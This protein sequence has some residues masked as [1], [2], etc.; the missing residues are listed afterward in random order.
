VVKSTRLSGL[1]ALRGLAAVGVV[2]YH[3]TIGYE[4]MFGQHSAAL[5]PH[6]LIQLFH[7]GHFGVELFF[8]ISGFVILMTLERSESLVSFGIS[9]FARLYPPY[10]ACSALTLGVIVFA[11]FNPQHLRF[12]DALAGL[13]MAS[14][15]F[16]RPEIDPSDWTLTYEVIF[17][18]LVGAFYF[19]RKSR[20]I[21]MFCL[22]GMAISLPFA[23]NIYYAYLFAAGMM[24]YRFSSGK[25]VA[26]TWVTFGAVLATPILRTRATAAQHLLYVLMIFAFMALVWLAG[27]GKLRQLERPVL[28]FLGDISYSLYLLHQIIGYWLI[29]RLEKW[30]LRPEAAVMAALSVSIGLASASRFLVELPVQRRIRQIYTKTFDPGL[31]VEPPAAA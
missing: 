19:A 8:I 13:T 21:E 7:Q 22:V 30:G 27:K 3:Y 10:V 18:I 25:A 31:V 29:S 16:H 4:I 14:S 17:Y 11:Q 2:L 26:L 23:L 28:L 15:L 12:A 6:M 24:I 9:R 20:Q 5:Q 1:D